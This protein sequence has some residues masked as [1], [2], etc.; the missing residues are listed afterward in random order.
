MATTPEVVIDHRR[1]AAFTD[2]AVGIRSHRGEH[3][4]DLAS[5]AVRHYECESIEQPETHG[6]LRERQGGQDPRVDYRGAH[7]CRSHRPVR[8]RR[9]QPLV[10]VAEKSGQRRH[11]AL[12]GSGCLER[13]PGRYNG[14]GGHYL[15]GPV[16]TRVTLS[17]KHRPRTT[18]GIA[19]RK[20]STHA[21]WKQEASCTSGAPADLRRAI[22]PTPRDGRGAFGE[23]GQG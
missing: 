16:W 1:C 18:V 19:D 12:H 8:H 10:P 20:G 9:R 15:S 2:E 23:S 11:S 22:G 17:V 5:A 4:P 7:G 21:I 14:R 3:R 13:R 6:R